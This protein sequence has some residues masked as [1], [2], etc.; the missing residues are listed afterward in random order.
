MKCVRIKRLLAAGDPNP[1]Y[2][3]DEKS[4]TDAIN[5]A[6]NENKPGLCLDD[7]D[8][9]NDTSMRSAVLIDHLVGY[10][11]RV[12]AESV[13]VNLTDYG[14]RLLSTPE[15]ID[16]V[17]IQFCMLGDKD[18]NGVYQITKVCK[19]NLLMKPIIRK[20]DD[21]YGNENQSKC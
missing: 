10:I 18:E 1:N 16:K 14:E 4:L 3:V 19:A 13:W 12:S 9:V 15:M 7:S 6:L 21:E 20:E 17:R 8:A 2:P 5:K 11:M